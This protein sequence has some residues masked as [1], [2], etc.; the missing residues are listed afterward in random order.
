MMQTLPS[1][2]AAPLVGSSPLE[3]PVNCWQISATP[4]AWT[5]EILAVSP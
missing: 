5:P 2:P 1:L 3:L 4:E